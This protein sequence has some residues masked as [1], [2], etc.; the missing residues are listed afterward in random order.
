MKN[1]FYSLL[2]KDFYVGLKLVNEKFQEAGIRDLMLIGGTA[3]QA[4]ILGLMSD[5]GQKPIE[6]LVNKNEV[7]PRDRIRQTDD[8]D[9]S[10]LCDDPRKVLQAIRSLDKHEVEYDR[11]NVFRTDVLRVGEKRPIVKVVSFGGE[12]IVRMN[13][14]SAPQDLERLDQA[15]FSYFVQNP[16][17]TNL[18]YDGIPLQMRVTKPEHLVSAKLA[19]YAPK[20]MFDIHSLIDTMEEKGAKFNY[21]EVK[22]IL[23]VEC[24]GKSGCSKDECME[25]FPFSGRYDAFVSERKQR[26]V[27]EQSLLA[28][29]TPP[30]QGKAILYIDEA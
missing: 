25:L 16:S 13:L 4:H 10:C 11:D 15:W 17:V 3:T 18:N 5:G 6:V 28:K 22:K 8:Y 29:P 14:L 9:L 12:A 30:S 7:S 21:A 27:K 20:D 23:G 26:A 24:T 1:A 19:R 2:D